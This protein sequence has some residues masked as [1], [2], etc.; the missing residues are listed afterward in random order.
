MLPGWTAPDYDDSAWKKAVPAPLD[1][2]WRERPIPP[3]DLGDFVPATLVKCGT[4]RRK[5]DGAT[6]ALTMMSDQ[7]YFTHEMPTR[8]KKDDGV[9]AI[10]D[11]G[12]ESVG[13]LNFVIDAPEGAVVDYA[14][15]EHL[16]DGIVRMYVGERNFADRYI[17]HEGTNRHEL[18]FHRCGLRYIQIN[19][20][21]LHGA[22]VRICTAG[23]RPWDYP[24]PEPAAFMSDDLR[25]PSLRDV[26]RRTLEHCMH[27]HF[28]DCPWREQSK[29]CYDSRNQA[30]YGYYLWGN[31]DFVRASYQLIADSWAAFGKELH[32]MTLCAPSILKITI[33]MFSFAWVSAARE[34]YLYG[35]DRSLFD[36]NRAMVKDILDDTC[37]R[38]DPATGLYHTGTDPRR[39]NFYEWTPGLEGAF[40]RGCPADEYH[41]VYNLY[42]IEMFDNCSALFSGA[43]GKIYSQRADDL[44]LAVHRA[45]WNAGKHAY[46]SRKNAD[47]F[48]PE[49]HDHTQYLAFR[50]RVVPDQKTASAVLKTLKSKKLHYAT[51]SAMPYLI[52]AMMPVSPEARSYAAELIR[53]TY[54]A[55]I[56]KGA[57][58]FWET[59][60]GASAFGN[61]GS[62]CHGWSSLPVYYQGAEVLGVR[63]LEPGFRRFRV[64]PYADFW[65]HFAEGTVP[66]P[67]GDIRIAWQKRDDGLY[68]R[69]HAPSGTQFV[70][71]SYPE[72][73]VVHVEKF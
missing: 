27:E 17:A 20:S 5:E 9:F 70:V 21:N 18:F 56:D 26:A 38:L 42:L 29:Y 13:F 1:A 49:Y 58:T 34:L 15:G 63:P 48:L 8:S 6:T 71:E 24:R 66:T 23:I 16:E 65:T 31:Y 35:N 47:G 57:T 33:P 54:G 19:V 44:R 39:W 69:V 60:N 55:M 25:A 64:R 51:L 52:D 72:C 32:L 28:E 62:L 67:H 50:N 41:A 59:Q 3:C 36:S 11:L 22:S 7:Y 53:T 30:L 4:F 43:I 10:F 40:N 68:L 12:V 73:P 37:S 45:F 46:A 2:V 14:H 61:A